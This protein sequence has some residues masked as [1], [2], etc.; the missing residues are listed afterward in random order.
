MLADEFPELAVLSQPATGGTAV[1]P[2]F[3]TDDVDALWQRALDAGAEVR[4]P[5]ADQF[6]GTRQSQIA[7]SFGHRWNLTQPLHEVPPDELARLAAAAFSLIP[8]QLLRV[9]RGRS[10]DPT[11][12]DSPKHDELDCHRSVDRTP[13]GH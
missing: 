9:G 10:A 6:W 4:Q 2:H 1:V 8:P 11:G 13:R 3:T 5:L 12:R 7:D